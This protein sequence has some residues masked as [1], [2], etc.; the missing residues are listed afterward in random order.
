MISTN[1]EFE[2]ECECQIQLRASAFFPS[3]GEAIK[4]VVLYAK[5]T[6]LQTNDK[7]VEKHDND[8]N[9]NLM[10]DPKP[11]LNYSVMSMP[12]GMS[13]FFLSVNRLFL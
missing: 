8:L 9:M 10:R 13:G 6:Y 1:N 11:T 7:L 5:R 4:R 3:A 12:A 2:C